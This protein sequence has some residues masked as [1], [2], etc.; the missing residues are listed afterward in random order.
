MR[1]I[2]VG[3]FEASKTIGSTGGERTTTGTGREREREREGGRERERLTCENS[4]TRG[5]VLA[6]T[7]AS[8]SAATKPFSRVMSLRSSSKF[9][10]TTTASFVIARSFLTAAVMVMA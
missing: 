10:R 7:K 9:L 5:M 6:E 3:I 1:Q 4:W 8:T 2:A